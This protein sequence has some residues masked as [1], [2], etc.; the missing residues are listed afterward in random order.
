M[1][2]SPEELRTIEIKEEKRH[3]YNR[4]DVDELLERAAATVERLEAENQ[5]LRSRLTQGSGGPSKPAPVAPNVER[6]FDTSAIQRTLV[7]AQQVADEAVA[8][9]RT[10]AQ[11]IVGDAQS[12]AH[13]LVEG[14]ESRAAEIAENE[15]KKLE[16]EIN[17]LQSARATLGVDVDA[18]EAFEREYRDRLRNALEA[19]LDS[20]S[21]ML[22]G[23]TKRP[24]VHSIS[25]PGPSN[26]SESWSQTGARTAQDSGSP[27]NWDPSPAGGWASDES[28]PAPGDE[29]LDDD[30]FFA[31]LRDAVR[32]EA[33]LGEEVVS[34]NE[35][36]G[37]QR[38]LFK[39]RK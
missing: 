28:S 1:D 30:A 25:L 34:S 35:D 17:T 29:S 4:D 9:A 16:D 37:E 5:Q 11:K 12:Q 2:I 6:S 10:Q 13:Q 3:G 8:D 39:R 27:A 14:A 36:T 33:P 24:D 31:S 7:L 19:E 15:R 18:L 38:K 20:F 21:R 22:A 23:G 32:E 26:A